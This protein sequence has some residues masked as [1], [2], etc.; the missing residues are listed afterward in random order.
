MKSQWLNLGLCSQRMF[1]GCRIGA[2][3]RVVDAVV[4]YPDPPLRRIPLPW[5]KGVQLDGSL[6]LL[7]GCPCL[8]KLPCP[9]LH[10]YG[11]PHLMIEVEV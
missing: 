6:L 5:L 4:H 10:S 3:G 11:D 8:R 7:Q 2:V 9:R 1:L